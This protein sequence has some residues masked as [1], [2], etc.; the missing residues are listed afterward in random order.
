MRGSFTYE[1]LM[2]RITKEDRDILNRIAKDNIEVVKE[3][4]LPLL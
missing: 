4:K 2:F 1:D 3:T